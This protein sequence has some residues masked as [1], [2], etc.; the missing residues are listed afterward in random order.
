[1]QNLRYLI[2]VKLLKLGSKL[3]FDSDSQKEKFKHAIN[4][5]SYIGGVAGS[6]GHILGEVKPMC[7]FD[8]VSVIN[9]LNHEM[10]LGPEINVTKQEFYYKETWLG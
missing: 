1:M 6:G 5:D 9:V 2:G 8:T 10:M 4:H 7:E 3:L